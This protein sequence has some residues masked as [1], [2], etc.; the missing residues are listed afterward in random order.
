MVIGDNANSMVI[1]DFFSDYPLVTAGITLV[2]L[3]AITCLLLS[4]YIGRRMRRRIYECVDFIIRNCHEQFFYSQSCMEFRK[5]GSLYLSINKHKLAWYYS[6]YNRNFACNYCKWYKRVMSFKGKVSVFM[7]EDHYFSHSEY[8]SCVDGVDFLKTTELFLTQEF[9]KYV[10]KR[11]PDSLASIEEY[12][13]ELERG[14][15]DVPQ[16]HNA[17]FVKEELERNKAYFDSV[18]SYPL[19]QQ[20][21]ESI[22]KLEDNCLVISSA[23]SG[24]TSTS[25]GKIKYLVEKRNAIFAV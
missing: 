25:V 5:Y 20:Q 14:F 13:C 24:K 7:T 21:R 12:K 19:D 1:L 17:K 8:L 16:A 10:N 15:S 2:I 23:G 22:V 4:W 11:I 3:V 18:L 6:N 9:L